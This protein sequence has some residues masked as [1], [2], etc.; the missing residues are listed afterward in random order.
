VASPDIPRL[1]SVGGATADR[2]KE[3]ALRRLNEVIPMIVQEFIE[4]AN[5]LQPK[6]LGVIQRD[7]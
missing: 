1:E 3:E 4:D 2:T 7:R 5:P 6:H